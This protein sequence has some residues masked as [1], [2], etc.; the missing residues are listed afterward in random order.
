M[1]YIPGI[2]VGAGDMAMNNIS[3]ISYIVDILVEGD[4]QVIKKMNK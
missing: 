4:R 1:Y 2:I 3:T